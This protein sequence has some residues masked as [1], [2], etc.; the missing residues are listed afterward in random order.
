MTPQSEPT[1]GARRAAFLDQMHFDDGE[2]VHKNIEWV[3]L[4]PIPIP[5]PNP[6]SRVEALKLHDLHHLLTGYGTDFRGEWEISGWE[7]GGGLHR[8]PVAWTF[9]LMGMTAGMFASPKRTL[10]AFVRGRRGRTLFGQDP[11]AVFAMTESAGHAFCGTEAE[12]A[13]ATGGD[14]WR[15]VAWGTLGIFTSLLPPIAWLLSRFGRDPD[16]KIGVDYANN[17]GKPPVGS[18]PSL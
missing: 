17:P 16:L 13:E 4:G 8:D 18:S 11:K 5:I 14:I 12:A 10:R 7:V 9:C 15:F 1:L 6:R 3:K 2:V